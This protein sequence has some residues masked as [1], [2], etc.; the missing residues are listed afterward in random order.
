LEVKSEKDRKPTATMPITARTRA[1]TTVGSWALKT[2]TA[3]IQ[4][5]RIRTQSRSEPSWL[6]QT[7]ENL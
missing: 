2:A 5:A 3:A 1:S 6:P 7:A 4:T